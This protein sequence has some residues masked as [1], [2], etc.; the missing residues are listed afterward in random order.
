[1]S[2]KSKNKLNAVGGLPNANPQVLPAK[3][4][5]ALQALTSAA[6]VL[7]GLLLTSAEAADPTLN[8]FSFQQ[9]RFQEGKRNLF[10][11]PNDLSPI[12]ADVLQ[13]A[14]SLS[15]TDRM[16]LSFGYTRD[17]WS[18]A[19]PVTSSPLAAGGN[20][21]VLQNA[22]G[23][24]TIVSG[25]SPTVT[26]LVTLDR[27]F[28]PIGQDGQVDTRSVEVLS[29]A[30]PEVRNAG[31]FS[32]G[33]EWNEAALRVG[34]GISRERDFNSGYGNVSGRLDFNQKL[35]SAKFGFG[36]TNNAISAIIDH[37][38]DTYLTKTAFEDQIEFSD[39]LRTLRGRRQDWAANIGLSQVL[40]KSALIDVNVGYTHSSGFMEN[41]YKAMTVIFVDPEF[42]NS[43]Q[44]TTEG[45]VQAL[46]EQRPNIRNQVAISA[47]YIQH[48][49][50]LDAAVHLDYKFSTDD[51]GINTNTFTADWIQPLGNGWT[52]TP[53]IRYH[54]QDAANFYQ[55]FLISQQQ[56]RSNAVDEF[57]R[58]VLQS[59]DDPDTLYFR[60]ENRNL[61]DSEGNQVDELS[62]NTQPKFVDFDNE[63]L[64][65]NFSSDHRLS[66]YGTLSGGVTLNKQI[67]K[68]LALRAGF[69]YF[70][71][72]SA[73]QIGGDSGG[74][75]GDF[76]F[77]VASAGLSINVE[78]FNFPNLSDGIGSSGGSEDHSKHDGHKQQ[79]GGHNLPA[80]VMSGHM[81]DKAGE[82][83]VGYRFMHG[84]MGGGILRGTSTA[85][86]LDIVNQGCE[87]KQCRLAPDYMNMNMHMLNVMYAPTNWLNLMVMPRFIDNKMNLRDLEGAPPTP[88]DEHEHSGT[89]HVT[90]GVG[91]TT[92]A[93]LIKLYNAPGHRLHLGL[94]ISAPTG[95]VR[96]EFRRVFRIDGG[97]VH[98][99]MQLG[100]GTW[101][102]VPSLTYT[103]DHKRLTWGAQLSG[104]KRL[105]K[106]N[107]SGYRLGDAIQA[108]TWGG[109]NLT[110]WLA[111]SVRGVFA[112]Q[113]AIHGDFNAFNARTG[114]MD[115]PG[116]QGGE[117]WDIGL[118]VNVNVPSGKF[119]GHNLSVE[120]LEPIHTDVNGFQLDRQGRLAAAWNYHF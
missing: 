31:D 101:D 115:F 8:S 29:F 110:R 23:G 120:W 36:Y 107:K 96:E 75:F 118:G 100:S 18:G 111:A 5:G 104:T 6:L 82:F 41:P 51:W 67:T 44:E 85:N 77:Y 70:T 89:P 83:M 28:N 27:D 99:G 16:T 81:L 26:G 43:N 55:P 3:P 7:P 117:Y 93:T 14:G 46:L 35:T 94:G 78:K 37:D 72:Q 64:P 48:I 39:G 9:S 87:D 1:M 119:A 17:V 58:Q 113:G 108:T 19:T 71:R 47:R 40:S 90:G 98:F 73:L 68:G 66:G 2:K 42:V 91:D 106:E 53:R 45:N 76:D 38:L 22:P 61:F 86:D 69:E 50:P 12:Q 54:S 95:S 109:Y 103:G 59:T 4:N 97:L 60:D 20:N 15:L 25:A 24:G 105:E 32:L 34:G 63:K 62:V 102:F 84:R 57:G 92:M 49:N 10:N 80:G 30:T 13:A 56:F 116:N 11:V 74:S 114:P 88:L 79:H 21:P 33:Y 112:K 52:I 65:D